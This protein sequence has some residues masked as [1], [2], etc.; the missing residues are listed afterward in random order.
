MPHFRLGSTYEASAFTSQLLPAYDASKA[1]LL[2]MSST[3]CQHAS[4]L[5]P[6]KATE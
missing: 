4:P 3:F 2:L 5:Q 6:E 1:Y